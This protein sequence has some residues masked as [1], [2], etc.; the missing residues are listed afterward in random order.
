L[1]RSLPKSLILWL[2]R[3]A[4]RLSFWSILQ[5]VGATHNPAELGGGAGVV[6]ENSE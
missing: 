1:D 3:A 2:V 6:I 4:F 5:E